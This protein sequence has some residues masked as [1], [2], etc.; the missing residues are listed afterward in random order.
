MAIRDKNVLWLILTTLLEREGE[1]GYMTE[2]ELKL[3]YN[4]S[5]RVLENNSPSV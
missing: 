4:I 1:R 3:Y 5:G 2:S